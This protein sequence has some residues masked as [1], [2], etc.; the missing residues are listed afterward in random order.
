[1]AGFQVDRIE[2]GEEVSYTFVKNVLVMAIDQWNHAVQQARERLQDPQILLKELDK[3]A[4]EKPEE[5]TQETLANIHESLCS[6]LP[7]VK[8]KATDGA[9]LNL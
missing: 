6:S 5:V 9:L 8:V 2:T 3:S 7:L 4:P 1:M